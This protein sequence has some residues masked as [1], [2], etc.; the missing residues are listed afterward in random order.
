VPAWGAGLILI[1]G[2]VSLLFA[3]GAGTRSPASAWSINRHALETARRLLAQPAAGGAPEEMP[4]AC[5]DYP[6]GIRSLY[7]EGLSPAETLQRVEI[8]SACWPSERAALLTGWRADALWVLGRHQEV[9]ESLAAVG[10]AP[11]MLS[12]A[13][14]SSRANDWD[15]VA[16]YLRCLPQ[17]APG[18]TWVSPWI[19]AR[20]YFGLGQHLEED[21][22]ID[23]AM[24]AYR[25]AALWY[26]TVWAAPYQREAQLLWQQGDEEQAIGLLADAVSR[27]T[28]PTAL[29]TLWRQLGQLWAQRDNGVD[30]LCAYRKASALA[31]RLPAGTLSESSRRSL[32]QDLDTLQQNTDPG[33]CFAGYPALRTP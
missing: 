18:D 29:F 13:E 32:L 10:A 19:V 26:P 30:A 20:L 12:L 17:L 33:V 25:A 31:D 23:A 28:D 11:R 7:Q 2:L 1:A 24:E 22:A 3:A 27:A 6:T 14:R 16:L 15:A 5:P 8:L 9:C 4:T 21:Q